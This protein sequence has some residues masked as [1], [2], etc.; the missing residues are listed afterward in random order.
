M[1]PTAAIVLIGNEILSGRTQDLNLAHMATALAKRGIKVTEARVISD[2]E[3]V[4]IDTINTLRKQND[5]VFTTGGIGPTHDDITAD[6]IAAALNIGIDIH[7]E[8]KRLLLDYW[9]S[10]NIEPNED[11]MRMA[12]IPYGAKLIEN[13]VSVAPG[14]QVENVFVMAGVPRIMQAMLDIVLPQLAQGD[15]IDSV[16]VRCNL[17][18]GV[19]AGPLRELQQAFPDIDLGSYPGKFEGA[20]QVTLVGRGSDGEQLALISEAL[21]KLVLAAGGKV[22][23]D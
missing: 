10:R 19:L 23:R 14:F 18:E 8:A 6:C 13:S 22:I 5:Y 9:K 1:T 20:P 7:P 15:V 4:I 11:R 17:G 21:H 12:R 16:S 2:T 3:S